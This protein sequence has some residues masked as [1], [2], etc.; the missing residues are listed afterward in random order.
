MTKLILPIYLLICLVAVQGMAQVEYTLDTGAYTIIE[1]SGPDTI[2]YLT[3]NHNLRTQSS[4]RLQS[5][6]SDGDIRIRATEDP[7]ILFR[8]SDGNENLKI[9]SRWGAAGGAI[10][11]SDV[12]NGDTNAIRLVTNFNG[13][14][15]ARVITDE[16]QI[17]GGSDL[18][19]MFEINELENEITPGLV[20]SLD[21]A[22]PG[23]LKIT[24]QIYDTKIVGIIAGAN[25]VKPG[26]LMGQKGSSAFGDDMIT[27]SGRTYVK[28]NSSGGPIMVGD[29]LTSSPLKGE[30]MKVKNI[31]R[32]RGSIIG[33]AMTPLE[34]GN[35][36]VL[37]LVNLQ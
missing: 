13:T 7:N 35:G 5:S 9:F 23:E 37:V 8:D 27:L 20:V 2:L 19:E 17:N 21:E 30:A 18:A 25:G 1:T 15:D 33:K 6:S 31:R 34:E 11:L 3:E 29:F 22:N 10:F 16:I 32:A 26:I 28:A 14:N 4:F 36:Y 24:D 12:I